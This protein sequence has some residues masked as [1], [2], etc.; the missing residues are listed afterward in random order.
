VL[1]VALGLASSLC[2]GISDFLG[3][4][5]SR[6]LDLLT[7]LLGVQLTGMVGA[8]VILALRGQGPP[9]GEALFLAARS[10]ISGVTGLAAFYRGLAVGAMSVVAPIAATGAVV[11]V[12]A[13]LIEGERPSSVQAAGVALAIV[14]V[15]VA[16]RE[17]PDSGSS[18]RL[19]TG[20]GLAFLAALG[21]GGFFV[22]FDRA[23][24]HDVFWALFAN[25]VTGV[26]GLALVVVALRPGLRRV[27]RRD[28]GTL[29]LIGGLDTGANALFAA[30]AGEGLVSIAAVLSSLYPVVTIA[31]AHLVL[32]ERV[33]PVQR[34]GVVGA[35][36]GV[37][38][39]SAG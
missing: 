29:A 33:R 1:A 31:L 5:K 34:V 19:A 8:G 21:F 24:Q 2:W 26:C 28:M 3:G 12:V 4:L 27:G 30:A 38:L 15:V 20:V 13:G 9:G 10:S 32:G 14:G 37:V 36:A 18:A 16:S 11:P 7:V 25:R 23:A 39:I 17:K 35:L 22:L 6:T